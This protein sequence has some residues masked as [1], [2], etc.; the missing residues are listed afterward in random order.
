MQVL[1][2]TSLEEAC[3]L[4]RGPLAFTSH[5]QHPTSHIAPIPI[6]GATDLLVHWPTNLPAHDKTYLDLSRLTSLR[7]HRWTPPT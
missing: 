7:P 4:M 6:A 5:I 2:P 3:A 1:M